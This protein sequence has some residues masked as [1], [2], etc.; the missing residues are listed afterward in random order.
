V[1]ERCAGVRL[2]LFWRMLKLL[3]PHVVESRKFVDGVGVVLTQSAAEFVADGVK[4]RHRSAFDFSTAAES[5]CSFWGDIERNWLMADLSDFVVT[6]RL[7]DRG[8]EV[9]I[10]RR[11]G[12]EMRVEGA[13]KLTF[14]TMMAQSSAKQ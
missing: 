2:A 1:V 6:A 11:D 9:E 10:R 12:K 13:T 8:W 7:R 5:G 14:T 3:M 4:K